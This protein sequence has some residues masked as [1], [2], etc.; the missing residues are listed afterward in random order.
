MIIPV[1]LY[2]HWIHHSIPSFMDMTDFFPISISHPAPQS[3]CH[4]CSYH[5]KMIGQLSHIIPSPYHPKTI[6]I[7]PNV[8]MSSPC[9][10]IPSCGR[11]WVGTM[12]Q[13]TLPARTSGSGQALGDSHAILGELFNK[14]P[15]VNYRTMENHH[16]LNWKTHY[17]NGNV[18]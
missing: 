16:V 10:K 3:I 14:Y 18:Q 2:H 13:D 15:L 6:P 8:L 12:D 4:I 5:P 9:P 7:L 11:S 1:E 17:F